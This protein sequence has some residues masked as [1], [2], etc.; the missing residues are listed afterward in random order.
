MK[1]WSEHKSAIFDL[2]TLENP[3]YTTC[4]ALSVNFNF[5]IFG[6]IRVEEGGGGKKENKRRGLGCLYM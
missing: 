2:I 6:A 5:F 1:E 4:L 3:T